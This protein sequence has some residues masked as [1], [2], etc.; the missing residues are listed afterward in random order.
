MGTRGHPLAIFAKRNPLFFPPRWREP[1]SEQSDVVAFSWRGI[2]DPSRFNE[3]CTTR[4]AASFLSE[5]SSIPP[6]LFS[7]PSATRPLLSRQN[8]IS[9][10]GFR[11]I[12]ESTLNHA[13][14]LMLHWAENYKWS[15]RTLLQLATPSRTTFCNWTLG[16]KLPNFTMIAHLHV[17]TANAV[18]QA[19]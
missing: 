11:Q 14:K 1:R 12:T 10:G 18:G 7:L 17:S 16:S 8:E 6:E 2:R 5:N 15:D 13:N 9:A 4:R 19:L 3:W